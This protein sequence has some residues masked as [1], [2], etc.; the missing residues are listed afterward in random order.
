[1][2]FKLNDS[3]I[4]K[5]THPCGNNVFTI[6]RTGADIKIKCQKCDHVIMLDRAQ[7]EK[8]VKKIIINE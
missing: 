4:M 6:V 3:V 2:D 5:K 7:F 1:M 8:K